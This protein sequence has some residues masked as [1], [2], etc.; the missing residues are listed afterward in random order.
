MSTPRPQVGSFFFGGGAG[1][2]QSLT[3]LCV[4]SIALVSEAFRGHLLGLSVPPLPHLASGDGSGS[5]QPPG[6][7]GWL[8][9][10]RLIKPLEALPA[11][12]C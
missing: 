6:L 8:N 7:F 2:V 11:C 1:R 4:P 9:E 10:F 5:N 12:F 3:Q